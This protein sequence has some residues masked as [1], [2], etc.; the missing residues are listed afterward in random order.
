MQVDWFWLGVGFIGGVVFFVAFSVY[1][2]F[3]M[4]GKSFNDLVSEYQRTGKIE[5]GRKTK[6]ETI[7]ELEK[8]LEDEKK[9]QGG[10]TS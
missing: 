2:A 9:K 5:F 4:T 8:Q 3:N 10:F 7:E 1:Q 6:K